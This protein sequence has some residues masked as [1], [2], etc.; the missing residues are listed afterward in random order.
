MVGIVA[1]SFFVTLLM[2]GTFLRLLEGV[3]TK[4]ISESQVPVAAKDNISRL[5]IIG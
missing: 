2:V 3:R 5:G 4:F 1:F